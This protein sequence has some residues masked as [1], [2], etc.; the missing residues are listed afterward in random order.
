[1]SIASLWQKYRRAGAQA[2]V[3]QQTYDKAVQD[4]ED[5]KDHLRRSLP[6][7]EECP[8]KVANLGDG[9]FAVH[10]WVASHSQSNQL[11]IV[12]LSDLEN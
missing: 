1:M 8:C 9:W 7:T 10:V 2:K 11:H 4:L 5:Y 12:N 3:A 6:L